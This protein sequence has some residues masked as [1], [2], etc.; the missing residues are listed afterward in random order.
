MVEEEDFQLMTSVRYDPIKPWLPSL[1]ASFSQ[2]SNFS[3]STSSD[4]TNLQ[5][6]SPIFLV[7]Y[8][9]DRLVEAADAFGWSEAAQRLKGVESVNEIQ[10]L[11]EVAIRKEKGGP[12]SGTSQSWK[13]C[14]AA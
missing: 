14:T 7:V 10:N 8:H 6:E 1:L 11:A 12:E 13:V 3:N 9:R 2:E 5:G 4:E